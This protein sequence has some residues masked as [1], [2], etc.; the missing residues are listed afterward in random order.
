MRLNLTA[1]VV[2]D[3]LLLLGVSTASDAQERWR[4]H[5]SR[6]N[7]TVYAPDSTCR[8]HCDHEYECSYQCSYEY[9]YHPR[10]YYRHKYHADKYYHDRYYHNRYKRY[11][12]QYDRWDN[13][14]YYYRGGGY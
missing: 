4:G 13:D 14:K 6:R 8:H 9:R 2:L 11:N 3:M 5:G 12:R 10:R 7:Y 1:F